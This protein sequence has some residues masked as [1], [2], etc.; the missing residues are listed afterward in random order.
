LRWQDGKFIP[1]DLDPGDSQIISRSIHECRTAY[2]DNPYFDM[3]EPYMEGQWKQIWPLIRESDFSRVLEIAPGYGRNSAKLAE[4]AGEIHLVDVNPA[5]IEK[6]RDRFSD[7]QG[8]CTFYF[9][10]N[11]GHTLP[12]ISP[13]SITFIYSWDSM[14]HFD[15]RVMRDYISEFARTL[16]PRGTGFIHHPNY[17]TVSDDTDWQSHPHCRSNMTRELF[18]AYCKDAGLRMVFQKI[19]DWGEKDLDCIS[20]FEKP[21]VQN[22]RR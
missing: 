6:C 22:G 1:S 13:D 4:H 11:D 19:I 3:A 5:C 14:V 10:V 9:Y 15:R 18:E 21:Y 12:E 2:Q 16:A 7:Y 17:G 8:T 20:I